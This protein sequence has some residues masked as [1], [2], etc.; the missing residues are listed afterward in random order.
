MMTKE[1]YQKT[2][3]RM[4][5]SLRGDAC[6]GDSNCNGVK[7]TICPLKPICRKE[8]I[9]LD[10]YDVIEFVEKWAKEHPAKTNREVFM[11]A[12]QEKFGDALDLDILNGMLDEQGC[13][14]INGE[15][16]SSGSC[17][18]C[19]QSKFWDK[20]YQEVK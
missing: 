11:E 1:E 4:W 14:L 8:N 10:I 12:M 13:N 3:I 2:L 5:D 18:T 6:K 17:K 16:H 15:C 19:D 7:C 9:F 20:E